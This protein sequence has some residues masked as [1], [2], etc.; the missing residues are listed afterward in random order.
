M[1]ISEVPRRDRQ[2]AGAEVSIPLPP[3]PSAFRP[4]TKSSWTTG[5]DTFVSTGASENVAA[6]LQRATSIG[7]ARDALNVAGWH[8]TIAGNRITVDDHI[9]AQYL[10]G[11][12]NLVGDRTAE[13]AIYG[14]SDGSVQCVS[15]TNYQL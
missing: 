12:T 14:R 15:A 6:I 1:T 13:W 10:S 7:A 9:S 8:A 5:V 3:T 2:H 11:S 4:T